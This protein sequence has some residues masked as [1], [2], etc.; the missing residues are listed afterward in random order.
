MITESER[1]RQVTI[2]AIRGIYRRSSVGCCLHAVTDDGNTDNGS[3]LHV[4]GY[5]LERGHDD[6]ITAAQGLHAMRRAGRRKAIAQA[7][8]RASS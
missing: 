2:S 7:L 5:A 8:A 4:L 1:A 3:V 6:C